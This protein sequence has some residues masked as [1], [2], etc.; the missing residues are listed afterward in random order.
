VTLSIE[1]RGFWKP[2]YVLRDEGREVGSVRVAG[3]GRN[4]ELRTERADWTLTP[5][6]WRSREVTGTSNDGRHLLLKG[7]FAKHLR[8]SD[9]REFRWNA[10]WWKRRRAWTDL[11][12][13]LEVVA[14]ASKGWRGQST[15]VARE[16]AAATDDE[17]V[18]LLALLGA[19]VLAGERQTAAAA[20]A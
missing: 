8:F 10:H 17:T 19:Y 9:G 16:G 4:A 7:S 15:V 5:K 12:T 18:R 2:V 1:P 14:F 11:A 3:F 13:G 20:A 6:G